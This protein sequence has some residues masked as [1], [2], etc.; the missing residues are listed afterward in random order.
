MINQQTKQQI[1]E[2]FEHYQQMIIESG[3]FDST[4][5]R[6]ESIENDIEERAKEL[7]IELYVEQDE[8]DYIKELQ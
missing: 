8:V 1:K 2:E 6:T 3:E 7:M 4:Y 5:I